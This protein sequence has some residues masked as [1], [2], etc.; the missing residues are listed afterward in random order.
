MWKQYG[1]EFAGTFLMV[2]LGCGSI[3][4]GWS[5]VAVSITFGVGVFIAIMIFQSHLCLHHRS[6]LKIVAL[7][8][9]L[10]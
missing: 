6:N 8:S 1:A 4:L 5:S 10:G 2:L 9:N 7:H 3:A